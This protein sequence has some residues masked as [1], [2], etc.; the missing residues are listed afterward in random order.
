MAL[1]WSLDYY[2]YSDAAAALLPIHTYAC[3]KKER[4]YTEK[5]RNLFC[6]ETWL[7]KESK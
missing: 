7:E 1:L 4:W 5:E 2:Y 6:R 3:V